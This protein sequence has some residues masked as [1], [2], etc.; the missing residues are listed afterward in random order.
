MSSLAGANDV[1]QSLG[2]ARPAAEQRRTELGSQDFLRLMLEQL[3]NQD[4]LKPVANEQFI[5]Q[6]A[7]L[8]TV[9]GIQDLNGQMSGMI[10]ALRGNQALS[11]ASL[12]GR[13]AMVEGATGTLGANGLAGGVELAGGGTVKVEILDAGGRT[14]RSL[15]LG[16]Q[17]AGFTSFTWDGRNT[18]G[19]VQPP[20][21]YGIRATV[22]GTTASTYVGARVESVALGPDGPTLTLAGLGPFALGRIR[23]F[24]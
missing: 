9:S 3:R 7:E 8:S 24:G 17:P 11:A 16:S 1:L 18:A 4:P 15:D 12:V 14:V 19:V 5:A 23:S 2:L 6:L 10:D 21:S 13:T 22:D 20:G